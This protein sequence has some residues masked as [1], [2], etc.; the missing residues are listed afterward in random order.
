MGLIESNHLS[1]RGD[2][3]TLNCCKVLKV[4]VIKFLQGKYKMT[5]ILKNVCPG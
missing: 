3:D 4:T 1:R 5:Q 2:I